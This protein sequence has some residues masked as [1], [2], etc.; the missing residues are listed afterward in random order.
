MLMASAES[1]FGSACRSD[2]VQGNRPVQL[3]IRFFFAYTGG[4]VEAEE[5]E[6]DN[7]KKRP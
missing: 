3:V 4:L 7:R 6:K 1:A 2:L 5:E